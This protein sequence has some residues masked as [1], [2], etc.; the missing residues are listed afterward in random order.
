MKIGI[1]GYG[2]IGRRHAHNLLSLGHR[3][4]VLLRSQGSGNAEGFEEMR[5]SLA[6]LSRRFDFVVIA[7]PSAKHFGVLAPAIDLDCCVLVEKPIVATQVEARNVAAALAR[8]TGTGMVAYNMRF[9]PCIATVRELLAEGRIGEPKYARFFVGQYL[10]D[11][12]QNQDY[13]RSYSVQ[14]ALGGGVALDLIH[15]VD[16]AL[17]L[18]GA[19]SGPVKGLLAR[20][21]DLTEDTEDVCDILYMSRQGTIV[22]VHMDYLTRGVRRNFEIIGTAGNLSCDLV[23]NTVVVSGDGN[24]VSTEVHHDGI[25]RN[26]MYLDLMEYYL[27]CLRDGRPAV[28][29]LAEGLESLQ[30]VLAAKADSGCS[31]GEGPYGP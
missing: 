1:V 28:P 26:R 31:M 11:W 22:E 2:S 3:D 8:Y 24:R 16:L 14:R 19:P 30:I 23:K 21:S 9:H 18:F 5:D 29:S 25:E 6:F 4:I 20:V 7:N 10:P 13:R 17:T 27:G 15:E 12:R